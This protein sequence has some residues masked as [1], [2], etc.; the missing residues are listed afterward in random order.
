MHG[1]AAAVGFHLYLMA[2]PPG[3]PEQ[4][5]GAVPD[6]F[7]GHFLDSWTGDPQTIPA[8]VRADR[9]AGNRLTMPVALLQQDWGAA[10]GFDA[11]ALWNAWAPDLSHTTVTCG[12]FMAEEAPAEVTKAIRALLAH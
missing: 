2:Q 9:D 10:L 7:F 3:L 5:I 11:S 1:V 4:L 6:L 8:D 12:H